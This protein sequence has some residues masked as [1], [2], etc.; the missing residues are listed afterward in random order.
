MNADKWKPNETSPKEPEVTH[1]CVDCKHFQF[2]DGVDSGPSEMGVCGK[3]A[4]ISL[5]SG[6]PCGMTKCTAMRS[7]IGSDGANFCG[8]K[9]KWF[10]M[11]RD[12]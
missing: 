6:E 7:Q 3:T 8:A 10:E 12:K 9:G 5:V 4:T 2:P 11:R 1:Y